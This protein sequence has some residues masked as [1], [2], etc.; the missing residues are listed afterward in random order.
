MFDFGHL[1]LPGTTDISFMDPVVVGRNV[2]S[3]TNN[4]VNGIVGYIQDIFCT[5]LD[6]ILDIIKGNCS[7]YAFI[8]TCVC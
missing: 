2:F 4:T 1:F 8:F 6:K 3:T 7:I 5:I